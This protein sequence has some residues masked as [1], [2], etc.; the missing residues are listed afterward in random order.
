MIG[1]L[2][3]LEYFENQKETEWGMLSLNTITP[4]LRKNKYN[5]D[6]HIR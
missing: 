6:D 2:N 5:N 1:V 3:D 4:L